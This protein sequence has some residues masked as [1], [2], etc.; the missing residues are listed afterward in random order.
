MVKIALLLPLDKVL[1]TFW[2]LPFQLGNQIARIVRGGD[3]NCQNENMELDN[4]ATHNSY[5]LN[6]QLKQKPSES[7]QKLI[8][9]GKGRVLFTVKSSQKINLILLTVHGWVKYSFKN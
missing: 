2:W 4:S 5:I 7:C 1:T 3:V 8:K 6:G 9:N